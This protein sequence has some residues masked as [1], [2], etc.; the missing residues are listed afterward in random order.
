MLITNST[1]TTKIKTSVNQS[2]MSLNLLTCLENAPL[3]TIIH[4]TH[5]GLKTITLSYHLTSDNYL[6]ISQ[7][8]HISP[9]NTKEKHKKKSNKFSLVKQKCHIT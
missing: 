6:I 3:K 4:R 5:I 2:T 9:T 7:L 1:T 8:N